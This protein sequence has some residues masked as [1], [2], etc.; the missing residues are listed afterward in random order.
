MKNILEIIICLLVC[1]ALALTGCSKDGDVGPIG[2]QGPQGEQGIQGI[3]GEQGIKGDTGNANIKH[4]DLVI[5][6]TDWTSNFHFGGNNEYRYY[7][8][9]SD[10][11]GGVNLFDFYD[12]G[13]A[14]LAYAMPIY[15]TES[16]RATASNMTKLLPYTAMVSTSSDKFGLLINLQV[17][18]NRL[19][20]AKTINGYEP[21]RIPDEDVPTTIEFRI[22]LIESSNAL[23]ETSGKTTNVLDNLKSSGVNVSNYAAV[24]N[25]F[26]LE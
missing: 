10:S 23:S 22:V 13:N 16:G 14:I 12:E 15:A 3:E 1:S 2:P 24:M 26:G 17:N 11:I 19:L 7:S 8:I 5:A 25:Y 21:D 9:P 4:Y 18:S 6:N 20:L